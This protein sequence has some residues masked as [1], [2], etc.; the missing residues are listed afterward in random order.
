MKTS[1]DK[2]CECYGPGDVIAGER[3]EEPFE[4]LH[5]CVCGRL[6]KPDWTREV[7]ND[8]RS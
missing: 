5:L 3:L 1:K 8:E 2:F 6:T 4:H 7:V